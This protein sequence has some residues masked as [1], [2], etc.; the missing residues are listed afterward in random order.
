MPLAEI[1]P[2]VPVLL[3]VGAVVVM[4]ILVLL[5]AR[6]PGPGAS[7]VYDPPQE[8]PEEGEATLTEVAEAASGEPDAEPG[9]NDQPS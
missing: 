9:E 8:S 7:G 2:R 5:S 4:V 6:R 1:D 3:A